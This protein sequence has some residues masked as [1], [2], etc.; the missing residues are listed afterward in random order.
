MK[1]AQL[2]FDLDNFED[3]L[4][5]QRINMQRVDLVLNVQRILKAKKIKGKVNNKSCVSWRVF[6]YEIEKEKLIIEGES[7]DISEPKEITYDA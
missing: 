1:R 6:N 5:K 7:Q 3:Y 4:H 2:E